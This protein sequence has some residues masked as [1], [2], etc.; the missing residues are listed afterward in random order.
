M[1]NVG[2]ESEKW[3]FQRYGHTVSAHQG[4]VRIAFPIF[5]RTLYGTDTK[6]LFFLHNRNKS[7]CFLSS[8]IN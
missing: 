3:P 4:K 7:Q 6:V 2:S 1:P 8:K 5:I